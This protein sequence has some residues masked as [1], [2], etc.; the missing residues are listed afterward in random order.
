MMP[1]KEAA[2]LL[3]VS[4]WWFAR[5]REKLNIRSY[6]HLVVRADV[7]AAA[8]QIKEGNDDETGNGT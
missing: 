6:G 3:G 1:A 4:R 2:E 7:E 5:H 8:G